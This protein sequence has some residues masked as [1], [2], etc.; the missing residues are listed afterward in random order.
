MVHWLFIVPE[1]YWKRLMRVVR[2]WLDRMT[3]K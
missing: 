3:I 1:L 2:E